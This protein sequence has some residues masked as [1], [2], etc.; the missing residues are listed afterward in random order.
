MADVVDEAAGGARTEA[1]AAVVAGA[2]A[3]GASTTGDG[4]AVTPR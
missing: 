3:R 2:G 1:G 4:L